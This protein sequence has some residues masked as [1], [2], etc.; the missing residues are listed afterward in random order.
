M[1]QQVEALINKIKTE[2]IQAAEQKAKEID[3]NAQKRADRI[4][5][6]ANKKAGQIIS[7]AERETEKMKASAQSAIQQAGRDTLL[8]L[9]KKIE[10]ILNVIITQDVKTVFSSDHLSEIISTA[11]K[12]YLKDSSVQGGI[13]VFLNESDAGR[14]KTGFLKRLQDEIKKPIEFESSAETAKGFSISFDSG[15]SSFDF[16][17]ASVAE[18]L[19]AY[20]NEEVASLFKGAVGK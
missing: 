12:G 17:D 18:Y 13:K 14:L 1:A 8:D 15:K 4:I 7:E 2:G 11:I 5:A 20:L 6:E 16:T 3:E 19:S 10:Q 9:R